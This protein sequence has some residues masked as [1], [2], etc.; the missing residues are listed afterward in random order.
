LLQLGDDLQDVREDWLRG[1][2]TLFTRAVSQGIPLDALVK[3]LLSFSE[4]VADGMES[5][6]NGS[7]VLKELMRMS[8]RSLIVGAVAES[9]QLFTTAFLDEAERISPFRFDFLR[10]RHA[11]FTSRQGLFAPLFD[12]FLEG[13]ESE[14]VL[15][16]PL[17]LS[18]LQ[19]NHLPMKALAIAG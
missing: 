17:V 9:H 13:E 2:N 14:Q 8:W 7:R 1:S 11:R 18:S 15:P 4:R 5:L 10:K 6:P 19:A 12:A 16:D 3:Q